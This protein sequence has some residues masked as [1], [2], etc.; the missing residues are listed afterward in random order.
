MNKKRAILSL[1][2]GG[3]LIAL[4]I[5][6]RRV[7]VFPM[8]GTGSL[9]VIHLGMLPI[10]F[11]SLIF[12]PLFGALIGASSDM[13]GSLMLPSG[14]TMPWP[15]IS[16][17]LFGFLPY[18]GVKLFRKVPSFIKL[19]I[20]GV[21]LVG[22]FAAIMATTLTTESMQYPFGFT[23]PDVTFTPLLRTLLLVGYGLLLVGLFVVIFLLNKKHQNKAENPFTGQV[24]DIS[25][26][27]LVTFIIVDMFY[28]SLWKTLQWEV[29]FNVNILMHTLIFV[30]LLPLQVALLK[31]VGDV[32]LKTNA[33]KLL[34]K[35]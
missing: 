29:A 23:S 12:G 15:I 4:S 25:F 16:A 28:S 30:V 27:L 17:A 3:L 33:G 14:I 2:V 31:I 20:T 13:L 11:S 34:N 24:L 7:F 18:F 22:V 35:D 6:L 21:L 5:V 1:T 32:F 19:T 26:A 8:M 9:Y 10:I